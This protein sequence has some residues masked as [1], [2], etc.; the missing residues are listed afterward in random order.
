LISQTSHLYEK[1]YHSRPDF[2]DGTKLFHRLCASHTPHGGKILEIGAGPSNPT[3][4]YFATLGSL[5][6]LDVSPEV[7][8]NR[9][10]KSWHLFDGARMPFEDN[11]FDGCFSNW[12]VEHIEMPVEHFREV[13][14]ILR[15]GKS[16]CFRTMNVLHY[17]G[18]ISRLS[19]HWFHR[20]VANRVRGLPEEAH[21]PWPTFYRCNSLRSVQ[22]ISRK[23]GFQT[24][25]VS[26][27]ETEPSYGKA[28]QLLF[29]PMFAWERM[30]NA[31]E[32]LRFLRAG[33]FGTVTKV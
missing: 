18:A 16:Y 12:V 19:P 24:V 3:S 9:A 10:L 15:P 26:M 13:N 5:S 7:A 33:I 1:H 20:A 8:N 31:T 14:R 32:T 11:S 29:Y 6:G 25:N 17:V 21:D 30:L 27:V 28:S 23:A 4:D 2:I 22:H